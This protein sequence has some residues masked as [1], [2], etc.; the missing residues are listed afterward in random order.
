[1]GIAFF[2]CFRKGWRILSPFLIL[3]FL[4]AGCPV[5]SKAGLKLH[6]K[7]E[8]DSLIEVRVKKTKSPNRRVDFQLLPNAERV[9]KT[10]PGDYSESIEVTIETAGRE[11][12]ATI[13]QLRTNRVVYTSAG[14]ELR[15][16]AK[17]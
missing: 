3:F 1:V 6:L 8:T 5:A 7:N 9:Y 13:A 2:V 14:F 17:R 4:L 12:A 11:V 15:A 10:A 16:V